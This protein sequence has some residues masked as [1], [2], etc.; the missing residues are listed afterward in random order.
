MGAAQSFLSY[1]F[2]SIFTGQPNE[3]D[4]SVRIMYSNN[5]T[6]SK[7][8]VWKLIPFH[9][10]AEG[11]GAFRQER[12]GLALKRETSIGGVIVIGTENSDTRT[13]TTSVDSYKADSF[14]IKE[15]L[16]SGQDWS[17]TVLYGIETNHDTQ[18]N[19][20]TRPNVEHTNETAEKTPSHGCDQQTG[21]RHLAIPVP[22]RGYLP[23]DSISLPQSSPARHWLAVQ[24]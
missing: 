13:V 20:L 8:R 24:R 17:R 7:L 11:S 6:W 12:K 22:A 15:H 4:L 16:T 19:A 21:E 2:E 14:R 18:A 1:F 23:K 10:S 3:Q 5:S 9:H